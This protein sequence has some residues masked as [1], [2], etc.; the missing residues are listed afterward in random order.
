MGTFDQIYLINLAR[1]SDRRHLMEYKLNQLNIGYELFVGTDGS[2]HANLSLGA[3]GLLHTYRR[4]LTEATHMKY[5]CILILEDDVNFIHGFDINSIIPAWD[6]Y[7]ILYLGANQSTFATSQLDEISKQ[8]GYYTASKS[9]L[10][11]TYGTYAIAIHS[12]MFEPIL[13]SLDKLDHPIDVVIYN[14]TPKNQGRILFPFMVMPDVS[15]SDTGS[16][17]VQL[18]FCSAR[19]YDI[20]NYKYISIAQ[21]N[22]II[23]HLS[24]NSISLRQLLY[25]SKGSKQQIIS[26]LPLI[27]DALKNVLEFLSPNSSI[28]DVKEFIDLI[29]CG[30]KSFCF[31][32]PSY[33]NIDNYQINLKSILD[34]DYPSY[35]SRIIYLDDQSN[36][37]TYDA[38]SKLTSHKLQLIKVPLRSDGMRSRQGFARYVGFHLTFDDEILVLLDGD[39]WLFDTNVLKHLARAYTADILMTYGSYYVY[40]ENCYWVSKSMN[41]RYNRVLHGTRS[42][43]SEVISNRSY[44][45]YDWIC[46][47]LRTGYAHLFKN[48]C[49]K[50]LMYNGFFLCIATDYAEM[51]PCMLMSDGKHLNMRIPLCVYNKSNSIQYDTS[52]Y[53]VGYEDIRSTIL[54]HLKRRSANPLDAQQYISTMSLDTDYEM[55]CG[56]LRMTGAICFVPNIAIDKYHYIDIVYGIVLFEFGANGIVDLPSDGIFN[57]NCPLIPLILDGEVGI[58]R[59]MMKK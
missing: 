40:D 16:T 38:V 10:F 5:K 3:I 15:D 7:S 17:R 34:Q 46:C 58:S 33:N 23:K 49:A 44:A 35:A 52:Y 41:V 42:Y 19:K 53:S 9:R 55:I 47:H 31:I 11:Q 48:I 43:P 26:Q 39:D 56:Y 30:H 28:F 36:D 12:R 22:E 51:I 25:R 14:L 29:H 59:K 20:R 50:D 45:D 6:E 24:D 4:L 37:G 57:S 27:A 8:L 18:D 32:V 13:A 54:A 21:F 1:R 2:D